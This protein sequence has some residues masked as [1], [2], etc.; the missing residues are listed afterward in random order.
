MRY[1]RQQT[2]LSQLAVML[3]TMWSRQIAKDAV[4]EG[5]VCL[6]AEEDVSDGLPSLPTLAARAGDVWHSSSEKEVVEPDP[7][8]P[9][10]H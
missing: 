4:P 1:D 3:V 9:Q 6:A 10:L 2:T 7:L 8:G 5:L